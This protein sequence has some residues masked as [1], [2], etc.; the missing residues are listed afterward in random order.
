MED[1]TIVVL[2]IVAGVVLFLGRG[3]LAS[4]FSGSVPGPADDGSIQLAYTHWRDVR[5]ALGLTQGYATVSALSESYDTAGLIAL[6]SGMGYDWR[7]I[8]AITI[9]ETE[10]GTSVA[11]MKDDNLFGISS[12]NVVYNYVNMAACVEHF[13][14]IMQHPIYDAAQSVKSNGQEFLTALSAAGYNSTSEWRDGV[15]AAYSE[16]A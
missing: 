15:L 14:R 12:D 9:H 1:L 13:L 10:F 7:A 3:G 4:I 5:S 2:L 16:L 11:A 6:F 8:A